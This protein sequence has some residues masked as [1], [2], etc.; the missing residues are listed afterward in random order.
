[1]MQPRISFGCCV[2]NDLIYIAGGLNGKMA[3]VANC[4]VYDIHDNK[5]L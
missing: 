3:A 5:W 2:S 1:M 4:D